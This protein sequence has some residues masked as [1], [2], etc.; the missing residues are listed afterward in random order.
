MLDLRRLR[1]FVTV[2][3]EL[4]FGRAALRLHIAQPPLTRH[5]AALE[6]ELG[7]RLFERSTRAVRLTPEGALFL[8]QARSVM[9]AV[10][11]AEATA[12]KM[13]QGIAG[14]IVIGYASSIP[15]SDAFSTLVRDAGRGMPDVELA[16]R[17]V[18]T[19]GQRQQ[20]ADGAMDIGFGWSAATAPDAR[21]RSLVVAREP[22]VAAV[23]AQSA[24]A[25]NA[26][27]AFADLAAEPFVTYPPGYGSALN[28]ALDDL[29]EQAGIAPRMGPTASQITTLVSLVAAERG[30]AIVPGFTSALQRPGVAYVPLAGAPVLEQ[31]VLWREPF[32]SAC[33]ERFVALAKALA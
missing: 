29:C 7:V 6:A 8:E 27:I 19:A 2:A 31:T 1:Y 13:A 5:I 33:V 11:D 14:R 30:V 28:A 20:I 4:H 21:L 12:R 26:T 23:P 9:Q 16:F 3:D 10:G 32:A 25:G 18:S 15:M 17:E 22:L 24:H